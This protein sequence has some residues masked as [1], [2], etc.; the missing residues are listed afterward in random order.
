MATSL[1]IDDELKSR[2][3]HLANQRRRSAHWLMLEAI[4]Q[5][6]EREEARESFRQEALASWQAYQETGQHLTGQEVRDWLKT[7][8][9]DN[10]QDTPE[11]HE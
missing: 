4:Q 3:Q 11:C 10:E 8:G 1:K 9:T 5:Y 2:V 7:W 6:V